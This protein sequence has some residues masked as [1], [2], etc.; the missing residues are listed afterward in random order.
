MDFAE[1]KELQA[2]KA[3]SNTITEMMAPQAERERAT[4]VSL[5]FICDAS[6]ARECGAYTFV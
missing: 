4:P 2:M 6:Y 5:D 3:A 1:R